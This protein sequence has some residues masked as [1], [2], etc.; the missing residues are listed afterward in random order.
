MFYFVMKFVLIATGSYFVLSGDIDWKPFLYASWWVSELF[1]RKEKEKKEKKRKDFWT[2]LYSPY[3]SCILYLVKISILLL[4]LAHVYTTNALLT[5]HVV[6]CMTYYSLK[7]N[8][9]ELITSFHNV[10]IWPDNFFLRK[11]WSDP[12]SMWMILSWWTGL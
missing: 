4:K 2:T 1:G 5:Y 6:K 8:I 12:N 9:S 11:C 3:P 7:K 10:Q